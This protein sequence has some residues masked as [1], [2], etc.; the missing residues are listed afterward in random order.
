MKSF[1][2]L[3]VAC[4]I[5]SFIVSFVLRAAYDIFCYVVLRPGP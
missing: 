4:F 3:L 1:L 2:K 5:I